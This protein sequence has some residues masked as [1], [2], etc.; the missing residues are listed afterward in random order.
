MKSWLKGGLIGVAISILLLLLIFVAL[1]LFL[2]KDNILFY[3]FPTI[4][5]ILMGIGMGS[6]GISFIEII[7]IVIFAILAFLP[8]FLIG[9]FVGWIVEKIKSRRERER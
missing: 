6:K 8:Y 1:K 7:Q 4:A 5:L 2:F 3:F 9:A